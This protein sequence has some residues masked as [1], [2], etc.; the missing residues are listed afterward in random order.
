MVIDNGCLVGVTHLVK[1]TTNIAIYFIA[2]FTYILCEHSPCLLN[3]IYST[4][5]L[6]VSI[7]L[8]FLLYSYFYTFRSKVPTSCEPQWYCTLLT[9]TRSSA[10]SRFYLQRDLRRFLSFFLDAEKSLSSHINHG[11]LKIYDISVNPFQGWEKFWKR[12]L[13]LFINVL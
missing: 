2:K 10:H 7:L 6:L 9:L 3:F 5:T 12:K 4:L 13:N 11:D 1:L 8:L